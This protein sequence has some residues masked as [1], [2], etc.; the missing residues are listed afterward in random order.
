MGW[1]PFAARKRR[2]EDLAAELMAADDEPNAVGFSWITFAAWAVK[3]LMWLLAKHP[4][5]ML[6]VIHAQRRIAENLPGEH[7]DAALEACAT[8]ERLY[9]ANKDTVA[10]TLR[11]LKQ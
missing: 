4:N 10:L 7:R 9:L 3:L 6:K 1:N 11:G 8:N 2:R 5:L